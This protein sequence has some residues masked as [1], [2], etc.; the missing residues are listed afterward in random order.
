M[1]KLI[2]LLLTTFTLSSCNNDDDKPK[3]EL[4]KLLK[5]QTELNGKVSKLRKE[6][7]DLDSSA[8]N[9]KKI[10]SLQKTDW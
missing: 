10:K 8:M 7:E 2:L 9:Q 4:E 6:I 3:T 5:E 1:K